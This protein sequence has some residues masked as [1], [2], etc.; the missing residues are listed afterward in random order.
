MIGVDVVKSSTIWG[1]MKTGIADRQAVTLFNS[2]CWMLVLFQRSFA[3]P[4]TERWRDAHSNDN[5]TFTLFGKIS[6]NGTRLSPSPTGRRCQ[7][8]SRRRPRR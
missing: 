2:E 8:R 7:W 1:M 6:W 4:A 3:G 5:L